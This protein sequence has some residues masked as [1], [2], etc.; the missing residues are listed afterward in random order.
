LF[1][2]E[3]HYENMKVQYSDEKRKVRHLPTPSYLITPPFLPH[4]ARKGDREELETR[5]SKKI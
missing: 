5:I 4:P 1:F 2:F 3:R